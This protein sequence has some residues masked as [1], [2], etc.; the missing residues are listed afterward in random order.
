[1]AD[2]GLSSSLLTPSQR[3]FLRGS[4]DMT[5]RGERAARSRIRN[6]IN[7]GM[8]DLGLL[9]RTLDGS[10]LNKA[11]EETNRT[12]ALAFHF[13][14]DVQPLFPEPD[15]NYPSIEE[16]EA[17]EQATGFD[18]IKEPG[19]PRDSSMSV[20]SDRIK[21]ALENALRVEWSASQHT[22]THD[23]D[24]DIEV[25]ISIRFVKIDR[26]SVADLEYQLQSGELAFHELAQ[27]FAQGKI[28]LAELQ[29][30]CRGE[31]VVGEISAERREELLSHPVPMLEGE[32]PEGYMRIKN[33]NA[34]NQ[35]TTRLHEDAIMPP[36]YVIRFNEDDWTAVVLED[37]GERAVA[38]YD[39]IESVNR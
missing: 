14:R 23:Y 8:S 19:E 36:G 33:T 39:N 17:M 22:P 30:L 11:L 25:D 29:Q 9:M 1:M 10:D 5:D 31:D 35:P 38:R 26:L 15:P 16:V 28:T 20:L 12:D 24:I 27:K 21:M 18:L 37:I 3:D 7:A 2:D 34:E 6:R 13:R 4:S 32:P